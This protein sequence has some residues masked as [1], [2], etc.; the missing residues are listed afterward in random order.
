MA[1][2]ASST[3]VRFPLPARP[4]DPDKRGYLRKDDELPANVV[5]FTDRRLDQVIRYM[6]VTRR[7]QR[8]LESLGLAGQ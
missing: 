2:Y 4:Y 8:A 7:L 5:W 1:E 3:V 6:P